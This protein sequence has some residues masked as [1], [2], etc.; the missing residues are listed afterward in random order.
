MRTLSPSNYLTSE[1]LMRVTKPDLLVGHNCDP[2]L[3]GGLFP[4]E[5]FTSVTKPSPISKS[6][7]TAA[8]LKLITALFSPSGL[9]G[10]TK[11]FFTRY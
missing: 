11:T 5:N 9:L 6:A 2:Y 3:T 8:A 1:N 10:K 7:W 4:L